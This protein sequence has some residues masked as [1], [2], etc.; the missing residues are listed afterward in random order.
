MVGG[1]DG[2]TRFTSGLAHIDR[3]EWAAAIADFDAILSFRP[4]NAG[5]WHNRARA[6][7]G[8]GDV[9]GAI[10]DVTRAIRIMPRNDQSY[11]V[12]AKFYRLKTQWDLAL[13][14]NN[15]ALALK[16]DAEAY[17][18]RGLTYEGKGDAAAAAADY[19]QALSI[20]PRLAR[21]TQAQTRNA[22][23]R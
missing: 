21:A 22:R 9:D 8:A 1:G 15:A 11:I 17:L 6:K 23:R 12:R 10:A 13:A 16:P 14:D 19:A 20:N 3:A 7:F 4:M 18:Q 5:A 2:E